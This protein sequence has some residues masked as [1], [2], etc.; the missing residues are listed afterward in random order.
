M[1]RKSPACFADGKSAARASGAAFESAR[2]MCTKASMLRKNHGSILERSKISSTLAPR[3]SASA[4]HKTRSG[5][6]VS[7]RGHNASSPSGAAAESCGRV[8]PVAAGFERA[9]C[10][11]QA[12]LE[13]APHRHRLAH[14]LHLRRQQIARAREFFEREA[15]QLRHHVVNRRLKTR[16]RFAR[17]VVWDFVERVAHRQLRGDFRNRKTRRLRRQRR[18]TRNAR[19]HFNHHQLAVRRVHAELNVGA[20]G[21]HANF[22]NDGD[23]RVAHDLVLAGR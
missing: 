23:R 7:M 11:L 8:E 15:R 6:G 5:R 22:A 12:L 10:F 21:V 1:R 13:G 20:A 3:R 17:D 18:R 2:S 9:Q 14:R 16:G 4:M 19:V